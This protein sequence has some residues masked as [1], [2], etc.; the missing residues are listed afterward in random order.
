MNCSTA[1]IKLGSVSK[2]NGA[3]VGLDEE[4]Y[5]SAWLALHPEDTVVMRDGTT[6][7]V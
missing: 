3:N 1:A 4:G 6:R 7:T 2:G 5:A